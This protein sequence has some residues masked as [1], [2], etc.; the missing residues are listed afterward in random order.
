MFEDLGKLGCRPRKSLSLTFPTPDQVPDGFLRHF[1]R[2]YFDGDG[3]ITFKIVAELK[4]PV[5]QIEGTKEFLESLRKYLGVNDISVNSKLNKRHKDRP[6]NAYNLR[7]GE[8]KGVKS[9]YHLF[10]DDATF[11]MK[12]KKDRFDSWIA[13]ESTREDKQNACKGRWRVL[14][15]EQAS[16]VKKRLSQKQT[17]ASIAL[18]FGCSVGTIFKIKKGQTYRDCV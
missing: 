5:I 4:C 12:R 9:I 14:S 13:L 2:G 3:C 17:I 8:A 6:T 11:W 7:I 10:Y 18:H 16:D 1:I 15:I